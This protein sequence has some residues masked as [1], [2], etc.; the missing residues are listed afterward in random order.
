MTKI[1][2]IFAW[3]CIVM[4]F[5]ETGA[6]FWSRRRSS[7]RRRS[8]PPPP[9]APPPCQPVRCVLSSWTTWSSC[10]YPC[11]NSGIISRT[12]YKLSIEN[13][14]GSCDHLREEQACNRDQCLPSKNA[15]STGS[16][17]TGCHCRAGYTGTCCRRGKL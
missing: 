5:T 7:R 15:G 10:S 14:C 1:T 11:G 6:V 13:S 2:T 8:A 17:Y 12:R 3:L 9:V 4:L 16:H